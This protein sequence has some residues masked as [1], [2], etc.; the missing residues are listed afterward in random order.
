MLADDET[1]REYCFQ[2]LINLTYFS[3]NTSISLSTN[4]KFYSLM[5][6]L[7][8]GPH[9]SSAFW[10][11]EHIAEDGALNWSSLSGQGVFVHL[12][13]FSVF[14]ETCRTVILLLQNCTE[15]ESSDVADL[16]WLAHWISSR[17]LDSQLDRNESRVGFECLHSCLTYG[18]TDLPS[19][20][21][22]LISDGMLKVEVA[23]VMARAGQPLTDLEK[24]TSAW[25]Q[26][27]AS[28]SPDNRDLLT[29]HCEL[30]RCCLT[31]NQLLSQASLLNCVG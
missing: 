15:L 29:W 25:E 1:Q 4:P 18:I 31:T 7:M 17:L 9:S 19:F 2:I 8:A 23:K 20:E 28:R 14:L 21:S 16:S 24:F 30:A 10:L 27:L 6:S 22:V 3:P 13:N 5:V 11:L 26:A 12:G